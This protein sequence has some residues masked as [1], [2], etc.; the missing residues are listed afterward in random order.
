VWLN[1]GNHED[2]NQNFK[3]TSQ[4]GRGFDKACQDAFGAAGRSL[5]EIH[6]RVFG[7]LPLAARIDRRIL[8]LHGGL[9]D[10]NWTLDDVRHVKRPLGSDDL[11]SVLDG[12]V[13]NILWSDPLQHT[14]SQ[15][16]TPQLAFGAHKSHRSKHT[17]VMKVFGRD[18][19]ERFCRREKLA[20]IIRS[21]QFKNPCKGYEIMHDGWLLRVFSARNYNGRV[22]NDGGS[23]LVGRSEDQPEVLLVKPQSIERQHRLAS[24]Q[25]L[26]TYMSNEPY[27][28]RQHLMQL[29][30]PKP[31]SC[32]GEMLNRGEAENVECARC[33]AEEL[34]KDCYFHCRGCGIKSD[35]SYNLCLAC[36]NVI[37]NGGS[38]TISDDDS[39]PGDLSENTF[40]LPMADA[41]ESSMSE[42]L[43][44]KEQ[45]GAGPAV[46]AEE[47]EEEKIDAD[48]A[49]VAAARELAP[50]PTFAAPPP[51]GGDVHSAAV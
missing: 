4:G 31:L 28:P 12:V 29:E 2:R 41:A 46:S 6:H 19:T 48:A 15:R 5:F 26:S 33:G 24:S 32:L 22:P 18:V 16:T 38:S 21:H 3:T 20:L 30:H 34:K 11:V 40:E 17:D 49:A 25:E 36:A 51:S 7:W 50:A 9:G 27:C 39:E 45:D 14:D 47:R 37:V 1:R 10:G 23:V 42:Q 35:R 44:V 13:Y 8:V 43:L